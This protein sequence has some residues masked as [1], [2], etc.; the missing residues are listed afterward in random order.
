V[1]RA[2]HPEMATVERCQLRLVQP[3]DD[4]ENSRIDKADIGIGVAVAELADPALIRW[5]QVLDQIGAIINVVEECDK[6]PSNSSGA[7]IV[8][9]ST[10]GIVAYDTSLW[11]HIHNSS[12]RPPRGRLRQRRRALT[13]ARPGP[14]IGQFGQSRRRVAGRGGRRRG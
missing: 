7:T 3:L 14:I 10:N 8:V 2:Q 9:R 4:R 11:H 6:N 13:G 12:E 5:E 1:A